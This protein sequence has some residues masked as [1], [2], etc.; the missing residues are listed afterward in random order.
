[1]QAKADEFAV[2]PAELAAAAEA[3]DAA[4][5]PTKKK[6][7]APLELDTAAATKAA[8]RRLVRARKKFTNL[9]KDNSGSLEGDEIKNLALWVFS[10]FRSP[11]SSKRMTED[12]KSAAVTR[13][14]EEADT[15]KDGK[16][17][18]DE[19]A[20]WYIMTCEEI[21][22]FHVQTSS[23]KKE[24]EEN[25]AADL[26]EKKEEAAAVRIQ[27]RQRGK[28]DRREIN[29]QKTAA[30]KMQSRQRGRSG[31]SKALA[32]KQ[33]VADQQAAADAAAAAE[34]AAAAA[35]EPAEPAAEVV[36]AADGKS[37]SSANS[38]APQKP[39]PPPPPAKLKINDMVAAIFK[40]Y[41]TDEDG[42]MKW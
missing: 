11:G 8:E 14:L 28:K 22:S 2:K 9:D 25:A 12:D 36:A 34:A 26:E 21:A 5:T 29:E 17:D 1:M 16:V 23:A 33:E 4:K 31:R 15:N 42:R 41:D 32:K 6:K 18:F 10:S 13:L 39:A 40:H 35:A 3:E 24:K 38:V 27:A 20:S 37:I 19:F 7:A 30:T